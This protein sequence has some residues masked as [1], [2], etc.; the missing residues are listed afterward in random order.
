MERNIQLYFCYKCCYFSVK[1]YVPMIRDGKEEKN[2]SSY[3]L[4]RL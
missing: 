1:F 4:V 2:E 3:T